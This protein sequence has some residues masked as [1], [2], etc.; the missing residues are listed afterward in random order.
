MPGEQRRQ[1]L[2]RGLPVGLP[3]VGDRGR[4]DGHGN[5]NVPYYSL[6][7]T[8]AGL[9]DVWRYMENTQ[10]RDVLL[11]MA[12]W[13]DTR[14]ARL[15]T[16]QMQTTLR[17][18]FG[19]MNAVLADLHFMTNDARWLTVAQRFDHAAVFD[20]LANNSDQLA[21]LHANTQVPKWIGAAREYKATGTTRYRDIARNAWALTVGA[22]TYAIGG[23]SQDEHFRAPNAISTYLSN[24]ACE[25]CNTYNMLKLTRELWLLDA[26]NAGYFDYYERA[27][28]T[29]SSGR[30]TLPTRT[31][32]SRT[33][34]RCS[35]AAGAASA[36]LGGGTWS[37]DYASFW[38]C[39]GT[40]SRP[41]RSSWTRST[42]RSGTT[43][44]VNLFMPSVLTW[45]ERG[46]TVTQTTSY[47]VSDTTT[48]T[49]DR[50]GRRSWTMRVRIPAWATGA[51]VA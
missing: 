16:A 28:S 5:G 21:G 19:G 15:T 8:L 30:R 1:R 49:V 7:K 6:H 17:V 46:I 47:P 32:T 48:L 9:L 18:E 38:C 31:V 13:V 36:R 42:S 26:E 29:T 50:L 12:A 3:R 24:D 41:T 2:R 35:P 4:G 43:L 45:T 39:Q 40:A 34:P 14:T 37:T 44:T 51:T 33:S 11:R 20:P 25:Q 22:H 23:N 10:A 27:C